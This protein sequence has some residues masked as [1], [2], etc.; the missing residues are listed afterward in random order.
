MLSPLNITLAT[1]CIYS[2]ATGFGV[3]GLMTRKKALRSTGCFFSLAGFFCQTAAL[4][5]GFHKSSAGFLSFGAY[6][7]LIAWFAVFCGI[8][9]W[10]RLKNGVILLFA[11]PFALILFLFSAPYLD[12]TI[13]VAPTLST[14]FY[15]LHIGALFL[16]L[17]LLALG[18]ICGIIFLVL[19]KKV[20]SKKQMQG[21]WHDMPALAILDKIN[22]ACALCAFPLY[23]LGI[24]AGL[25]WAIP[26]YGQNL[27]HDPKELASLL[28]WL[29]LAV[30]F[31]NRLAKNWRG[32]KP[33][34][35][36]IIIF[37]L[38]MASI[39]FVNFMM[40]THH[41]ISASQPASFQ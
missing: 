5:L 2:L 40:T 11:V 31:H 6:L 15:A 7:Q 38:S 4:I 22:S 14:P 19:E 29:L 33:A 25:F 21:L 36:I 12:L 28:V 13:P 32:R 16:G 24:L 20:K 26:L 8:L 9:A 27:I 34:I 3:A 23:T 30:L 1:L 35:L 17:G 37:L 39:F 10:W 18:F 41:G